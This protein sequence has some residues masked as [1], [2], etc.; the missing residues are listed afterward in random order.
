VV[1]CGQRPDLRADAPGVP[2]T[3]F[4]RESDVRFTSPSRRAAGL[5]A[6]A[7]IGLSTTVLSLTGVASAAVGDESTV[8]TDS[9]DPTDAP[10]A[11]ATAPQSDSVSES[12]PVE[13][14]SAPVASADPEVA[15]AAAAAVAPSAPVVS[16]WV[17]EGD[18]TAKFT[19]TPGAEGDAPPTSWEYQ[20]DGGTW[21]T[22]TTGFTGSDDLTGTLTGLTNLHEYTL[23]VRA[24]SSAG[25]GAASAPVTFMPFHSLSAPTGVTGT[26]GV[27]SIRISWQP[28]AD[29]GVASYEAYAN[30]ENAQ[31]SANVVLCTTD[32]SG[33]ACTVQVPAGQAYWVGVAAVDAAGNRGDGASPETVTAVV[34]ASAT[35]ATLPAASAPLT[36]SD[37]DGKVKVGEQ[38]TLTGDGYLAGSNVELIVYSTPVSLGTVQAGADGRFTATVTLPAG[39]ANGTHHLVASGVDAA[40]N[41]RY[42]VSEITVS[43]GTGLAYTGFSALPYIGAG[44]LAL[45][46]GGGLLVASRRRAG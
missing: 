26:V 40:G 34:P 24:V 6:A 37:A 32:A 1:E 23:S 4:L 12:A 38:V 2:G 16:E 36:S 35:P 42:L 17:E 10:D 18:T 15:A 8:A 29:A 14:P 11:T 43:G 27:T 44:A 31:S 30:P 25:N 33:R 21:T 41:P 9:T 45:L 13:Q 19:F 39:L 22:F 3:F 46:A 20:L 28:S 7:T 5:L